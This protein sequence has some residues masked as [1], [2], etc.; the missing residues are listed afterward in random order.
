MLSN[1]TKMK[2][3]SQAIALGL[4]S[5]SVDVV[6]P[7][8]LQVVKTFNSHSGPISDLDCRQHI[9]MTCGTS[10]RKQGYVPDPLVN[11]YDLRA[12]KPLPPIPFPAGAAYIKIHP[13][14][15][16]CCIIA[17]Q[18]GQLQFADSANPTSVFI[19]QAAIT[20]P[21]TSLELSP[22]GDYLS[23]TDEEGY[24]H[25]WSNTVNP[26]ASFSEFS[27]PLD[28]PTS[29]DPPLH[30]GVDDDVSLATVGMPYYKEELLSSWS[31]EDMVFK[32]GMPSPKIDRSILAGMK[33][34]DYVGYGSYKKTREPRNMAQ[35]YISL[36]SNRRSSI[37]VPRFISEKERTGEIDDESAIFDDDVRDDDKRPN[38]KTNTQAPSSRKITKMYR[39]LEIKYSKFGVNDF[40]FDFY[41]KTQYAGLENQAANTYCNS[42][43]QLYR[44]SK[45]MY[46]FALKKL[47]VATTVERVSLLSEL[48]FVFD[49]LHL[50]GGKHCCTANFVNAL[51][52][53]PEAVALGLVFDDMVPNLDQP[54]L[55]LQK[56]KTFLMEQI[57]KNEKYQTLS[58]ENQLQNVHSNPAALATLPSEFESSVAGIP[59]STSIRCLSCGTDSIKKSTIYELDLQTE[60]GFRNNSSAGPGPNTANFDSLFFKALNSSLDKTNKV[61]GW[62]DVCRKYQQLVTTRSATKLPQV[63]NVNINI[64][65]EADTSV[66][67]QIWASPHWP[68]TE[69]FTDNHSRRLVANHRVGKDKYEL[70]G[71]VVE[72]SRPGHSDHHLVSVV[73]IDEAW[74]LFNDFLVKQIPEKD[75]LDFSLAW[76]TPVLLV[77]QLANEMPKEFDYGSWKQTL[78]TSI[79]Y[80]D[81]FT[82]GNREEVRREYELLTLEEA[83][84]PGTLVAIDAE[85]VMLQNEETEI[86]SDG[87][88]SIVKPRSLSLARVSVVRGEGP[89]EGVAFIDDYIATTDTIVDYLTEFSGIEPGDLDPALSKR[90]L[91]SL[92]TAYK[93]LWLL[94]QLGVTF[95]GHGLSNDFR[96]INIQVP[97][98]QVIDTLDI[99]FVRARQRKLSLKF[100]AWYLLDE[101][102]QTG[103]HDSIEDARTALHLYKKHQQLLR[104]GTFDATLA[105]VYSEGH[106]YNFRPPAN[107]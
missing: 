21:L 36:D 83:P 45:Y 48:G 61:R 1:V 20:S 40:D 63:L 89:K 94:L 66:S 27:A 22:S 100:L 44:Y 64:F 50:A 46:N 57:V 82:A 69:F 60:Y 39:R 49:M 78:D 13:K 55:V 71:C 86:R 87:T 53:I 4:A 95:V 76:K 19:H 17:S 72:I 101:N 42:I 7:N 23:L 92:H 80:K 88:K 97:A 6:D 14:M 102:V 59:V 96:T 38:G 104:D 79:L 18:S 52:S 103:N 91:V 2:R 75:A 77:Y 106:K 84:K 62:C 5:G 67:R 10:L 107:S 15:S 33:V 34:V 30:F 37:T 51:S 32:L 90:G 85:F 68:P 105:K 29:Q 74:Y 41:N 73:K 43:L 26:S 81:F 31:N 16:T 11:C 24:I 47:A 58:V 70:L 54:G 3:D 93:R 25:L 65:P 35:K 9:I 8:S 12:M 56:F 28:F 99:Y 98:N